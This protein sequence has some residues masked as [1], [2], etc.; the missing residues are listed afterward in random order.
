MATVLSDSDALDAAL[1]ARHKL[2]IGTQAVEVEI[3]G[4][5]GANMRTRFTPANLE[6]LDSYIAELRER[7]GIAEQPR[8][9]AI[10]IVF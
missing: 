9:G 1:A 3:I 10:G 2:L 5:S 7:L 8:R 6:K 4:T